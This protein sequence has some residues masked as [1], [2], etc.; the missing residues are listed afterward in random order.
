MEVAP[1]FWQDRPLQHRPAGAAQRQPSEP[2]PA[3][4]FQ[5]PALA[6]QDSLRNEGILIIAALV[7]VYIMLGILYESYIHPITILST[8]PS[9][10]V[11]AILALQLCHMGPFPSHSPPFPTRDHGNRAARASKRSPP[12]N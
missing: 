12:L 2:V 9:A 10:G 11:G 4:A 3:A 6:F 1:R 8:L 5:D 7:S